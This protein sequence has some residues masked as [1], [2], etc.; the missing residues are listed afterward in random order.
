MRSPK[1]RVKSHQVEK[2]ET[3]K[4]KAEVEDEIPETAIVRKRIAREKMKM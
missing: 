4:R 3:P 2:G 1:I